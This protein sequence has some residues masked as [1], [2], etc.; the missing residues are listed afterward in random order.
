DGAELVTDGERA[1]LL[2]R[3]YTERLAACAGFPALCEGEYHLGDGGFAAEDA[4]RLEILHR[5]YQS[6]RLLC[7][8]R[9]RA[10]GVEAVNAWLHRRHHPG[11]AALAPGEP[12]LMLRNDYERGLYN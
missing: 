5:H 1:A 10:T 11:S 8:T 6:F 9:A 2:E 3:W 4:A 12:I 7:L